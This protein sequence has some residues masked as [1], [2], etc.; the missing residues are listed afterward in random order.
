[1]PNNRLL[2]KRATENGMQMA[3]TWNSCANCNN[4]QVAR[5]PLN[6]FRIFS[7]LLWSYLSSLISILELW[8]HFITCFLYDQKKECI[9]WQQPFI[10]VPM[11][12]ICLR[13]FRISNFKL[14]VS[15]LLKCHIHSSIWSEW[16]N[17]IEM[18]LLIAYA[19]RL[20]QNIH[21]NDI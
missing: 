10:L 7:D 17:R 5:L 11:I 3:I 12:C 4:F 21:F 13:K 8:L 15:E 2:M 14:C 1:M 19:A 20:G 16:V 18:I 9:K 6:S